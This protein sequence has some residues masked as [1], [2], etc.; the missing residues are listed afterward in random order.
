MNIAEIL[1]KNFSI[2]NDDIVGGLTNAHHPGRLEY[3]GRYLFDGAHNIGGARALGEFIREFETRSITLVF[4]AMSDKNAAE[5]LTIL[6]PLAERIIVTEPSNLRAM[7]YGELLEQL[8][9]DISRET[10]FAT[11]NVQSAIDI[12]N[13]ITPDDGIVLVTGSLYLVGEVKGI[14]QSQ[15]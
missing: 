13:E 2:T 7:S 1:R 10:T 9:S 4:G 15:I 12:A 8:P 3:M 11:N 5:I 6:A 14:L